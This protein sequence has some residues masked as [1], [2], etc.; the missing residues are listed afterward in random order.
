MKDMIK[1]MVQEMV[2]QSIKE[3]MAEMMGTTPVVANAE[4][5]EPVKVKSGMSREEFLSLEE[6]VEVAEKMPLDFDV[7]KVPCGRGFANVVKYNQFVP[8]DVWTVNHLAITANY[9]G[10]WSGKFKG[11]TFPDVG[12][13]RVFLNSYH[14]KSKLDENDRNNVKVYKAERAKAKAEYYA[15]LAK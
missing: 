13:L 3:V 1:A 7:V 15:N 5:V 14:I 2:A 11:Y 6:P 4:V 12:T 9:G 8:S 10:K